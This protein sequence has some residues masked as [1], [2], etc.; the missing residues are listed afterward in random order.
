VRLTAICY[1]VILVVFFVWLSILSISTRKDILFAQNATSPISGSNP[2]MASNNDGL[3][4]KST[5]KAEK[6]QLLREGTGVQS[7]H[8]VFRVTGNRVV[9]TTTGSERFFCLENLNL[10]RIVEVIRN[11]PTL[12]DWNVDYTVT[13]YQGENYVLIQRAVL[14]STAQRMGASK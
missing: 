8:V 4:K 13:E 12:T 9:L 11:N 5:A 7:Q 2:E 14:T 6:R 3:G 10:Q 1:I